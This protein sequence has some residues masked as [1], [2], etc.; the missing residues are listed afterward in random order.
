MKQMTQMYKIKIFLLLTS[1]IL[2]SACAVKKEQCVGCDTETLWR[3]NIGQ[4]LKSQQNEYTQF[5]KDVGDAKRAG[6]LTDQQV[7]NLNVIGHDW[8]TA[9]E[10]SNAAYK[11]YVA[12]PN[13]D[14]KQK[15]INLITAG[16]QIFIKLTQMK[17]SLMTGGTN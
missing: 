7:T 12:A 6:T 3:L 10:T 15:V 17:T 14:Q 16:E 2:I 9:L 8:K 13:A 1:I 4:E 11:A 5:F